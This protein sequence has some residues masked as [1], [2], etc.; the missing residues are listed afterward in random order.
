MLNN[1]LPS[2]Y[3]AADNT[4]T[5]SQS[6]FLKIITIDIIFMILAAIFAIYNY[7]NID[8]KIIVYKISGVMLLISLIMTI[9]LR[10]FRY[11]DMWYQGRSLAESCKTLTWRFIMCSEYFEHTLQEPEAKDRFINRINE[12]KGEFPNL[13]SELDADI[14]NLPIITS[15]MIEIRGY[16]LSERKEYYVTNRLEDQKNWYAKKSK[17]NKKASR[18]WFYIIISTQFLALIF[19]TYLILNPNS[20][21]NIIGLL[22]T[23]STSAISWQQT[24]QFQ[25]LSQAYTTATLELNTILTQAENIF[26]EDQL[27]RFILDSE[28]AISREHTV[29]LAQKRR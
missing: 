29:W 4:S 11:E 20:N 24:K 14:L 13:I 18:I 22:T 25:S 21:W 26:S 1:D 27:S 23:I 15:K 19:I 28:N 2:I 12:I 8:S 6:W 3:K 16:N 10:S 5:Y 9:I 17:Q 7:Q